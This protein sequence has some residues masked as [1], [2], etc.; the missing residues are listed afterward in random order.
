MNI[1][2]RLPNGEAV[3]VVVDPS[4]KAKYLFDYVQGMDKD[5]GFEKD[6]DRNFNIIRPYDKLNL[7][8]NLTRSLKEVFEGSDSENLVVSE[9]WV[10]MMKVN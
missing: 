1:R 2:L 6:A 8:E 4:E 9:A 5:I 10:K 3:I 7:G